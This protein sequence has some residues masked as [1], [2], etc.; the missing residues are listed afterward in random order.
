[1]KSYGKLP[2]SFE[3]NQGQTDSQVEFLS[4]GPGYALFL[5]RNEAV[6]SLRAQKKPVPPHS[7][8]RAEASPPQKRTA[9]QWPQFASLTALLDKPQ[10]LRARP[11]VQEDT[12][13]SD[14]VH[15]KVV[16]ANPRPKVVGV[17]EL[18]GKSNYFI[19][20]EPKNWRT[21]VP[22]YARVRYQDVYPGVDLV[23]YGN[24]QQLEYDF[25]VAP[26]ADASVISLAVL[27][28]PALSE[29]A[30]SPS[31]RNTPPLQIG[32]NGDLV[33]KADSGEIRLHK[34]VVYQDHWPGVRDY[35]SVGKTRPTDDG[36]RT[37]DK[38]NRQSAIGNRQFLD[39]RYVLTAHNRVRFEIPR[40]DKT[41][42]LVIDPVL[43]YS[44]YL[45]GTGGDGASGIAVDSSGN[46]YV[47]GTTTSTDFPTVHALQATCGSCSSGASD[48]FVTKLNAA[49]SA[50]VYSTY[51][52][53][54]AINVGSSVAVDS[55]GNAYVIGATTSTDFPTVHALQATCGG[56]CGTYDAFLTK[57]NA[58][59]SALVY[60]TF[61]GGSNDDT[62]TS[63]AVDSSGNAYVT[64]FTNST[65]FPIVNALQT[66]CPDCS[67][68]NTDAFVTKLNAAGTALVYSTYLGGS[69]AEFSLGI[70]V[71]SSGNAYVVGRTDSADFPTV[72]AV[73]ATCA[74]CSSGSSDTFVTKLNAT[75]R[76][77]VYSTYLGGGDDDLGNGI[78]VDASGNAYVT[79]TTFSTD[80]PTVNPL[81]ATCAGCSSASG[82]SDA[83]LT[84]F[85]A[86]G[87][88]LVYSTYLGGSGSDGG[89]SIAVDSSGNAF[90]TGSTTSTDFPTVNPL[91]AMCAGCSSASGI[92]DAFLTRFNA[93]GTALVYSTYLRGSGS[94]G[95]SSIA[96]DSSGNA[97]V[98]GGTNSTD[99]PTLN[100]IQSYGG[101]GDIFV[102]KI[103]PPVSL[104]PQPLAFSGQI[105]ATTS[106]AQTV[107]L[108]NASGAT[109]TISALSAS[110]DFAVASGTTC[111]VSSPVAAGSNCRINVTFT[112]RASGSR[113][114][115]LTIADSDPTSPQTLALTGIGEDFGVAVASGSSSSA[116]VSAGRTVNYTISVSPLGGFNQAVTMSC[117]GAP[118]LSTCTPSVSSVALN[119]T[120]SQNVTF[121]VTTTASNLLA[122]RVRSF[123]PFV[124]G[125]LLMPLLAFAVV[126]ARR[127]A[128]SKPAFLVLA[129]VLASLAYL[130]ACGGGGSAATRNPGTP[131]GTYTLTISGTSASLSHSTQV[132]LKVQ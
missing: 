50:L 34:P 124:Y 76:S 95:G 92:S 98:T 17:D 6:L 54:S 15:L 18:P 130:A 96:V 125:S 41:R 81:Q 88:A 59:G 53:G 93:T 65:D 28:T 19:G 5:T 47:T 112:P 101:A 77:L 24:Q 94:D 40:Y 83:F 114:G 70:A 62:G 86:A 49:G 69:L 8:F 43:I 20:K 42:P 75:G 57:L 52:G 120:N 21:N 39:G 117:T 71:D 111:S 32:G 63:I 36:L 129:L 56:G 73:Q 102:T 127:R 55:S 66:M 122:Q 27:A 68:G 7:F 109:L 106:Y 37:T 85:N 38:L 90:V 45:G 115:T 132:T 126:V 60:S 74:S 67:S 79:G 116:T 9:D 23:Y 99:F 26:G 13:A 22:N 3:A 113:T 123:T 12:P 131:H 91:Q 108:T 87:T 35:N 48:V 128:V 16:G 30:G 2:L 107:S 97:F 14:I 11:A 61:L 100:P 46:A 44:T 64:G 89:S 121:T 10:G 29:I 25:V 1:M 82:I 104:S 84:R 118:S 80:F 72:N 78:A 119:G 33:V 58:V 103:S 105:L 51:L 31:P 4:R 110:G